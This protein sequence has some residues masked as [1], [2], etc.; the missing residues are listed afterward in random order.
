LGGEELTFLGKEKARMDHAWRAVCV[1]RKMFRSRLSGRERIILT[2]S[3]CKSMGGEKSAFTEAKARAMRWRLP[4][5]TTLR[6]AF[7]S[8]RSMGTPQG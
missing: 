1:S 8:F 5:C 4:G 2:D 6:R 3:F 7:F